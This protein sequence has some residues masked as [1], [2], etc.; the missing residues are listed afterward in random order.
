MLSRDVTLSRDCE[1]AAPRDVTLPRESLMSRGAAR[2]AVV[3]VC[4]IEQLVMRNH[5]GITTFTASSHLKYKEMISSE[6]VTFDTW[7][8]NS[9]MVLI[10][11]LDIMLQFYS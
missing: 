3:L 7:N 1:V 9:G 11:T 2:V 4:S 10:D 6:E 5:L 8:T